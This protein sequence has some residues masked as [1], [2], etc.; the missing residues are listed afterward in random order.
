M[1]DS[2]KTQIALA[3]VARFNTDIRKTNGYN[4]DLAEELGGGGARRPGRDW[5]PRGFPQVIVSAWRVTG[6]EGFNDAYQRVVQFALMLYLEPPDDPEAEL[7]DYLQAFVDDV[8][9]CVGG[10]RQGATPYLGVTRCADVIPIDATLMPHDPEDDSDNWLSALMSVEAH[11]EQDIADP[12][13]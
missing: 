8:E 13:A 6:D 10:I 7:E 11:F 3:L 9:R 4:Y 12:T 2:V 1:A 5:T